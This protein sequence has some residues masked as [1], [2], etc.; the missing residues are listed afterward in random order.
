MFEFKVWKGKQKA[1][2]N[3]TSKGFK[4]TVDFDDMTLMEF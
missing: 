4:T 2:D 1:F 3:M